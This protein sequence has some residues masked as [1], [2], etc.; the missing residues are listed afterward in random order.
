M[1]NSS[2]ESK[3]FKLVLM[4]EFPVKLG[5]MVHTSNFSCAYFKVLGSA[6]KKIGV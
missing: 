5:L 3:P 4:P 1:K 6:H 2:S